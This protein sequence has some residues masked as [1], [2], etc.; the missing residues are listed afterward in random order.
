MTG[1]LYLCFLHS[2]HLF[3]LISSQ[4]IITTIDSLS[5]TEVIFS[6]TKADQWIIF[7]TKWNI[8]IF[9]F[10]SIFYVDLIFI[11]WSNQHWTDCIFISNLYNFFFF[12]VF[13]LG[14]QKDLTAIL[15]IIQNRHHASFNS[16]IKT[17]K[18]TT[19]QQKVPTHLLL[20]L[21][22]YSHSHC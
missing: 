3:I 9:N 18:P 20:I 8:S 10:S 15:D 7:Q 22:D 2:V 14:K 17:R 12:F 11:T 16:M 1:Y 13:K 19:Y 6:H 21:Q 5:P 4:V